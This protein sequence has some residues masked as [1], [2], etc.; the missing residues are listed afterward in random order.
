MTTLN[1]WG[2]E[3]VPLFVR[4]FRHHS[5]TS[6]EKCPELAGPRGMSQLAQGLGFDLA[7]TL[8]GDGE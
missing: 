7:D 1:F 8:A 6:W 3:V 4:K 2:Q 5:C